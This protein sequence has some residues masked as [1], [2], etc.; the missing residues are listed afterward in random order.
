MS[1]DLAAPTCLDEEAAVLGG[2]LLSSR[3]FGSLVVD[4]GLR[5]EH[6]YRDKHRAIFGAMLA[7]DARGDAIDTLTVAGEL[8]RGGESRPDARLAVDELTGSVPNLGGIRT[9]ARR[10]VEV[11]EIRHKLLVAYD[12]VA[13]VRAQDLD[14]IADA[15]GRLM[16][17][18][19]SAKT[20][21]KPTEM[22]DEV[23]QFLEGDGGERWSLPWVKLTR[24]LAGGIRR[25]QVVVIGGHSSHGKSAV[26]DDLLDTIV[27]RTGANA[28][29]YINEMTRQER[30]LRYIARRTGL[31]LGRLMQPDTAKL[32]EREWK[33]ILDAAALFPWS[34]VEAEGWTADEIGR[35]LRQTRPDVALVD[36]FQL[37]ATSGETRD[38]D[39]A[40]RVLNA[41]AKQA[42]CALIVTTH[43]NESR[44]ETVRPKPVLGDIRNTGQLK[45]DA[46]TV[47]FV[48]REQERDLDGGVELLDDG[49]IYVAK[50]RMGVA[51]AEQ[52]VTFDGKHMR[53]LSRDAVR[54]TTTDTNKEMPF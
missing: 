7:L 9:Y 20:V 12:I 1:A 48:W 42:N 26:A 49:L 6:F 19:S 33:L 54:A 52:P 25:G 36:I 43:L 10:V 31:D 13:A 4:E 29:I 35:H 27:G 15:E 17:G 40:S 39:R 28:T 24:A 16:T 41:A 45:N 2:V 5:A 30:Q 47:L 8:A 46:D 51:G 22:G 50:A 34:L 11:A 21:W 32:D 14:A 44:S 3:V 53:F 23:V 38:W 37:I 18:N